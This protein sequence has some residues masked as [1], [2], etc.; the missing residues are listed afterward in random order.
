MKSQGSEGKC[1]KLQKKNNGKISFLTLY[2]YFMILYLNIYDLKR[3]INL[4]INL[5]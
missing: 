4:K 2:I 1:G 5:P 3:K